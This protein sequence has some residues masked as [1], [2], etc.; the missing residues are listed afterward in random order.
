MGAR[1]GLAVSLLIAWDKFKEVK[2]GDHAGESTQKKN[3]CARSANPIT[4]SR[5]ISPMTYHSRR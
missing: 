4:I 2:S 3:L 1:P 5:A